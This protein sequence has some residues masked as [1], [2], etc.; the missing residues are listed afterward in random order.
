M[1]L[2]QI[3]PWLPETERNKVLKKL[4]GQV[5]LQFPATYIRKLPKSPLRYNL[6]CDSQ[7]VTKAVPFSIASKS[8]KTLEKYNAKYLSVN[9]SDI[10]KELA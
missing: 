4:N 3:L 1:L 10:L 9:V 2:D 5:I 6:G 7:A 8:I